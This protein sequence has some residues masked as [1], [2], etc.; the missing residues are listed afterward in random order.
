MPCDV[1]QAD[2][3]RAAETRKRAMDDEL[4]LAQQQAQLA[5]RAARQAES[6]VCVCMRVRA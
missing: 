5:V 1:T 6:Q 4:A 2:L 3:D